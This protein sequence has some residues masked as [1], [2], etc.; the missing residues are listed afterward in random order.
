MI[1]HR[2]APVLSKKSAYC[3]NQETD[4]E[5]FLLPKAPAAVWIPGNS[6]AQ[7]IQGVCSDYPGTGFMS[8]SMD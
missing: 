6:W 2:P 1:I 4:K 8:G 7:V 3:L 5:V